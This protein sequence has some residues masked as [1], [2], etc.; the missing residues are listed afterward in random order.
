MSWIKTKIMKIIE[1]QNRNQNLENTCFNQT[2]KI[3]VTNKNK[4]NNYLSP[5]HVRH[6]TEINIKTL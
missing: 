3:K 4:K 5:N 6:F 1:N 2:I